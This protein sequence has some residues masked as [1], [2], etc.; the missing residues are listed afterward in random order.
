MWADVLKTYRNEWQFSA[1]IFIWLLLNTAAEKKPKR[2][3]C[4][5]SRKFMLGIPSDVLKVL[6]RQLQ[7]ALLIL[8][9]HEDMSPA[10]RPGLM[11][12][13]LPLRATDFWKHARKGSAPPFRAA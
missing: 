13:I 9:S 12:Q 4:F 6:G 10:D 2:K 11:E 7:P 5:P 8:S 1:S 3:L